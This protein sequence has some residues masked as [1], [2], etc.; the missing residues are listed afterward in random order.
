MSMSALLCGVV[1]DMLLADDLGWGD[2]G[3]HGSKIATP[4]IDLL[5][6]RGVQLNQLRR[7]RTAG[8]EPV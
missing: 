2:V 6:R 5:A 7:I 4:H 3:F 8:F 1:R